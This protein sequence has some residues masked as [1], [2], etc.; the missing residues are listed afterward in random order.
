MGCLT[1]ES[2]TFGPVVESGSGGLHARRV[3]A[4]NT[5]PAAPR[6]KTNSVADIVRYRTGTEFFLGSFFVVIVP[7]LTHGLPCTGHVFFLN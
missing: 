1:T 2:V 7:T 3:G 4:A 5:P 6:R